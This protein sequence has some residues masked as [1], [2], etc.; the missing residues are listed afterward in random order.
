MTK[1]PQQCSKKERKKENWCSKQSKLIAIVSPTHIVGERVCGLREMVTWRNVACR[2]L[3]FVF[4][5]LSVFLVLISCLT[6]GLERRVYIPISRWFR[7][8]MNWFGKPSKTGH[9][10]WTRTAFGGWIRH[11]YESA[12]R[13]QGCWTSTLT[14]IRPNPT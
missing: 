4:F 8:L 6:L 11:C 14:S 1:I 13:R 12:R 10:L 2:L 9:R 7:P 3:S 5:L